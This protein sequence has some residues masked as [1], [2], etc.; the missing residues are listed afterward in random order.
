N[1]FRT[2]FNYYTPAGYSLDKNDNNTEL[3]GYF[4]EKISI[5]KDKLILEPSLRIHYYASLPEA[6]I[7]P[8]FGMKWNISDKVRFKFAGGYFT[9]NLISAVSERDIV[10]LFVGFLSSPEDVAVSGTRVKGSSLLQ[11][12]WHAITG[13]EYDVTNDFTINVEPYYKWYPQLITLN[14]NKRFV[15]D[16]EFQTETGDAY[17]IDFSFKYT[18]RHWNVTTNYSYAFVTRFDGTQTYPTSFDRRHNMNIFGNYTFG[19]SH[20]WEAGVRWNFGTGFPFTL[21]KGFYDNI[22]LGDIADNPATANGDIGIIYDEV[23]NGGRLPSY[24]RL[25]LS[26]KKSF[27]FGKYAALDITASVTNA[28]NRNNIF[29]FDRVRYTRVDQLPLLPSLAMQFRF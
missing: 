17:G 19:K 1:G 26:L 24:H 22:S 12:S 18:K 4:K 2:T 15:S 20:S 3:A 28:Y 13:L 10:N 11:K 5:G 23:R 8:R 29:Y 27:S 6:S 21:T 14:R 16:S 7:E 25:D 9:Q